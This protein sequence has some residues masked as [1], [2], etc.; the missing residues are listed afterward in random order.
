MGYGPSSSRGNTYHYFFCLGRHTKK[1]NC[2]M[3]YVE[4]SKVEE[5]VLRIINRQ[6]RISKEDVEV[7]GKLAHEQL[8]QELGDDSRAAEH[9]TK[10]IKQLERDKQKPIDAYLADAIAMEDVKPQHEEI[11]REIATLKARQA[12][13]GRDAA[14]LHKSAS[15]RSLKWHTAP[16]SSTEQQT[17]QPNRLYSDC[18][19]LP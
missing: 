15:M 7:G 1:T 6:V 13:Y 19:S 12:D 11:S 2:K 17:R 16:H 10:R 9:A 4:E 5:D 18:S 14:V 3:P 8:D